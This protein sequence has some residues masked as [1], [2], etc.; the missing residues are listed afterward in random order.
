MK[1]VWVPLAVLAL[2]TGLWLAFKSKNPAAPAPPS[3]PESATAATN[4]N[5][6]PAPAAPAVSAATPAVPAAAP[7]L[8][9]QMVA[10][11]AAASGTSSTPP[12][13]A[14]ST[15]PPLT[16]LDNARVVMHNYADMF[17][18]NPVGDNSEITAALMGKNPK[19]VNFI[20]AESGLRVNDKGELIDAWGTP[21]F[22][23]QLSGKLMEI[24]SAGEDKKM[25]TFDDQVTR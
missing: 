7:L 2:A 9:T 11:F 8:T 17:G 3:S 6:L 25:W 14:I 4:G 23:H 16:V 20:S 24:R 22:F 15:L 18:E 10:A 1:K 5:V 19:Q 12:A 21:F 13:T